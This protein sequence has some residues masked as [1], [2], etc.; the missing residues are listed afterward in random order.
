MSLGLVEE[1]G[2][3]MQ[4]NFYIS[5]KVSLYSFVSQPDYGYNVFDQFKFRII[6]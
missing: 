5:P 6:G 2:L 4:L 3:K 1:K